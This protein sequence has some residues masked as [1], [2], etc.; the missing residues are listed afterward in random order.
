MILLAFIIILTYLIF[1][2]RYA[3]RVFEKGEEVN[4]IVD[5]Q[6]GFMVIM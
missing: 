5:K 6:L 3:I 1:S 2:T 4:F